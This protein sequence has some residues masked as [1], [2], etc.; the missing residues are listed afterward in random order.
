MAIIEIILVVIISGFYVFIL[1]DTD[2]LKKEIKSLKNEY[3]QLKEDV[4]KYILAKKVDSEWEDDNA[5]N[6]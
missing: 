1:L 5:N 4:Y 2:Q 6:S 3:N